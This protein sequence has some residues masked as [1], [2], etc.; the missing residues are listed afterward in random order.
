MYESFFNFHRR[1]FSATP[2]PSCAYRTS[3]LQTIVDELVVC[4]ERGEGIAVLTGAM[5]LGKTLFCEKVKQE[6]GAGFVTI[7]LRHANFSSRA[8]LLRTFLSELG[9]TCT[10]S[11][12]HECRLQFLS[13]LAELRKKGQLLVVICDEA[14]D[15][16][17]PLLEEL[18]QLVDHA[19]HGV[20]WVRL[21]LSGQMEL[22]EKLANPELTAL[23]QRLR[24]HLTLSSLTAA[25]S[26]DYIDYR[27]TW[28][29]GRTEEIFEAATLQEIVAAADGSP[30]CIN[31]LCDHV[32]LLAYVA[33][34]RPAKPELVREAL[35]DLQHL[36]L[37]WNVRAL[38]D[39]EEF[40]SNIEQHD[41]D[42]TES[43]VTFGN[44][45]NTWESSPT[46]TAAKS[47]LDS[48]DTSVWEFGAE[49]SESEH[50]EENPGES[51]PAPT[52]EETPPRDAFENFLQTVENE[53]QRL[54][55]QIAATKQPEDK[56]EEEAVVDR[57]AAIDAGWPEPEIPQPV[58]L[59]TDDLLDLRSTEIIS[60]TPSARTAKRIDDEPLIS[61]SPLVEAL[62]PEQQIHSD[63]LELVSTTQEAMNTRRID[64][65]ATPQYSPTESH[66]AETVETSAPRVLPERP[67]RNLFTR[68]R[69]KQK[70]LE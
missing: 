25:E 35:A 46:F 20:A 49:T 59:A 4:L 21:L 54:E 43:R 15:L 5:G 45:L 68:L 11:T 33:E 19:D 17:E 40:S 23:N 1:P 63:V 67:F 27:I 22:E 39:A 24:S 47:L 2:D 66:A 38:R 30:R 70:G 8:D 13:T 44:H 12:E 62:E 57:Y 29:G 41:A 32:L 14:H 69:R 64:Q 18:R 6:L 50:S 28:S 3:A 10:T 34:Q 60:S 53:L 16:T 31:Q 7:L 55:S 51:A 9:R 48:S 37:S 42:A 36:P 56:I 26:L 65:G 52:S 61:V 58:Q